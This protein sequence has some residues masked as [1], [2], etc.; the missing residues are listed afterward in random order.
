MDTSAFVLNIFETTFSDKEE[1][2]IASSAGEVPVL[3]CEQRTLCPGSTIVEAENGPRWCHD[4]QEAAVVMVLL[5]VFE[6]LRVEG[7][8][9]VKRRSRVRAAAARQISRSQE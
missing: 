7:D 2:I 4:G 5:C 8:A 6:A 9:K 3:R 1:L